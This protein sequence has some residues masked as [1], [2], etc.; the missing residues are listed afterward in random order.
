MERRLRIRQAS[1]DDMASIAELSRK[2]A[3]YVGDPDPGS[4]APC[5]QTVALEMIDGSNASLPRKVVA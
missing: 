1:F 2:L 5:Y 3:A 4:D